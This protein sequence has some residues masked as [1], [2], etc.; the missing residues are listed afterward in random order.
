[1]SNDLEYLELRALP[2]INTSG[3]KLTK[4]FLLEGEKIM[5]PQSKIYFVIQLH[6]CVTQ[7]LMRDCL[8]FSFTNNILLS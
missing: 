1:M 7:N 3:L 6:D 4:N 5:I 2:I 8:A